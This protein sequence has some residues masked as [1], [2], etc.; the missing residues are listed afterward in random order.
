METGQDVHEEN[1]EERT[2]G[3][4]LGNSAG[5]CEGWGRPKRCAQGGGGRREVH[6]EDV[7]KSGRHGDTSHGETKAPNLAK[8]K[9]PSKVGI[10]HEE[11]K[12]LS[13]AKVYSMKKM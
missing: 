10:K 8:I 2:L 9:C 4:T 12:G 5:D 7:D 1:E 13:D 3:A 6:K 11:G